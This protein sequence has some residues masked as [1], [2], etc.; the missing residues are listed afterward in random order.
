[1]ICGET[2]ISQNSY[3][4]CYLLPRQQGEDEGMSCL[5]YATRRWSRPD[6]PEL[7][8]RPIQNSEETTE[9]DSGA[10]GSAFYL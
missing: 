1:M 9:F 3:L 6:L 10:E 2:S 8:T 5:V 4:L 7:Y